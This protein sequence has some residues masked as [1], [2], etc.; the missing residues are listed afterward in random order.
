[1]F[2]LA[3]TLLKAGREQYNN[4]EVPRSWT[5]RSRTI[6]RNKQPLKRCDIA[7]RQQLQRRTAHRAPPECFLH[8]LRKQN[9]GKFHLFWIVY[10]TTVAPEC[11]TILKPFCVKRADSQVIKHNNNKTKELLWW[12]KYQCPCKETLHC[13]YPSIPPSLHPS[14]SLTQ[15]LPSLPQ[16][17]T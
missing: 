4:S 13:I 7:N 8:N 14:L 1:M 10:I 11:S 12:T 16:L 6:L 5:Y 17:A 15:S 3:Q 2:L 9:N